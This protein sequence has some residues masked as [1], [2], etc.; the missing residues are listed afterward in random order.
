MGYVHVLCIRKKTEYSSEKNPLKEIMR[1]NV[2]G[3]KDIIQYK[4]LACLI[5]IFYL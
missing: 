1:Q 4:E 5:H 2:L 3:K